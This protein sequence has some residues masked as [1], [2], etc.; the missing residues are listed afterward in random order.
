MNDFKTVAYTGMYF[1]N[2]IFE[3]IS[4]EVDNIIVELSRDGLKMDT[5]L[6]D[7][8]E[9]SLTIQPLAEG[10][11]SYT[12]SQIS[13]DSFSKASGEFTIRLPMFEVL[14]TNRGIVT[15]L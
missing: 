4:D 13:E 8:T 2:I 12:V 9:T 14:S 7:G 3:K 5:Y 6:C 11:Y 10:K 15:R 1:V